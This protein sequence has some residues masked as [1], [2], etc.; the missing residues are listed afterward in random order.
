MLAPDLAYAFRQPKDVSGP[1]LEVLTRQQSSS[2]TATT[3]TTT[4]MGVP[5]D[6]ILILSN[7]SVRGDP[8]ATQACV[9]IE[10]RGFTAAGL[11]F[12]IITS[13]PAIVADLTQVLNWQGQVFLLGR[14]IGETI[15]EV[16]CFYD[17]GVNANANRV[18]FHGAVI[19]RANVSPY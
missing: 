1:T 15:V 8:G 17:A 9:A 6:R 2:A 14:G 18:G 10:V 4:I 12:D 19:P 13:N 7:V 16:N 3:V 11:L 5:Q